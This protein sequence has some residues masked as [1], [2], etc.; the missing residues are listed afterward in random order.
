MDKKGNGI[1]KRKMGEFY[2]QKAAQYLCSQGVNILECNY[3]NHIGE[4]DLIGQEDDYLVFFEVKYRKDNQKG[5]PAEAVT[6]SKQRTICKVADYYRMC[7]G[8][9][10]SAAIRYDVIAVCGKEWTWYRN[11]FAHI[12]TY[13]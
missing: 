2:E 13:R 5:A 3:R 11:A 9:G 10:E 12:Y 6:Y 4:I 7:H 8:I 1:N